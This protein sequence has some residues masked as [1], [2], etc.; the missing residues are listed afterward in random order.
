MPFKS[1][2]VI[3]LGY[4]GLPTAV[5]LAQAGLQVTGVDVKK[6]T[7]DSV[8]AGQLPFVEAGL[9]EALKA[10]VSA[11][12][13][14]AQSEPPHADAYIVAVPTPFK[15]HHQADLSFILE[16]ARNIAP[17]LQGNELVILE[18][19][20][21]P[22]ATEQ[23]AAE[24]LSARSDLTDQPGLPNSVYFSHAPERVLP[25]RIMVE[26]SQ[27]DRIIGGTT[28]HAAELNR[29]LYST[30][31]NGELLVTDART[32][33]MAKLTENAFRD[34]NI[35]FANELSIIADDLDINVWELIEL[36]NHHP[37]VNILQPGPGVGGHCIAVDP[38]F[39]VSA[40]PE[41]AKL[42]E[43]ARNVNDHKPQVVLNKVYEAVKRIEKPTIA[44]LGIAFKPDVDDLRQSPSKAIA[45][46]LS[47]TL[48]AAKLLIVEPN[49]E[50]LPPELNTRNNVAL[51]APGNALSVA[52]VIVL[53]V[54][55]TPFRH[56][57]LTP[58]TAQTLID[59]RGISSDSLDYNTK[60][61]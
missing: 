53:L 31:C 20:S 39:I 29:Q 3:G 32:A 61:K 38:W 25:G 14:T 18:S 59:T 27:N 16:A 4:I 36:A 10:V 30:F 49:I 60:S 44:V 17:Q 48:P 34:V 2:A 37:R 22:G 5:V 57:S 9:G 58:K 43:T 47:E 1:V 19:T 41:N 24:I 35:A 50:Q 54:D 12:A 40:S 15:Q 21:P 28:P 6:S 33:E 7:V 42:I 11:G 8:N 23:M 45:V 26:M 55:H 51:T 52:D 13:L 46:Q 56:L